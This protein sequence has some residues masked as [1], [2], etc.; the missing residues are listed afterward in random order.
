V[1]GHGISHFF[2]SLIPFDI[3]VK[4]VLFGAKAAVERTVR[5]ETFSIAA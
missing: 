4:S 3:A 1:G 2:A 5:K